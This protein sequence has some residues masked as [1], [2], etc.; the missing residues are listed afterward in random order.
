MPQERM[1]IYLKSVACGTSA[2][3]E[4]LCDTYCTL[5]DDV[6]SRQ[7]KIELLAGEGNIEGLEKLFEAGYTQ[8]EIDTAL[9]NAIA[10]SKNKAAEY[11]LSLGADISND[12][13]QGAYYAAHNNEIEGLKFAVANGVDINV[14][15]GM[16]LNV[17]IEQATN[18]K[19]VDI[20]KW[21]LDNGADPKFIT[22]RS[23]KLVNNYGTKELKKL[24]DNIS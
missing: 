9:V 5:M 7:T 3:P 11:L 19:S 4:T 1:C 24:I 18:T 16:L 14:E 21:L 22:G 6:E 8:L 13:Y 12:N 10:Y 2:S 23:Q 17:S 20:V 15:N